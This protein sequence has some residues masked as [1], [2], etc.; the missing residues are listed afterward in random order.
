MLRAHGMKLML[1]CCHMSHVLW[2]VYLVPILSR[3]LASTSFPGTC[4]MSS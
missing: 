4:Q 2:L 3:I 1:S